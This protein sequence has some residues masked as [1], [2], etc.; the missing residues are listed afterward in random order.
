M[1]NGFDEAVDFVLRHEGGYSNN[2]KDPGGETNFGI[3][4]RAYPGLYLS[5]LTRDQAKEIYRRDFW[6]KLPAGLPDRL[7]AV[8]FDCAVNCG[9]SRA[10]RLLQKAMGVDADGIWGL[11]SQAAVARLGE[12]E[13]ISRFAT[14]RIL[15]Y[16]GLKEFPVFGKGWVKRVVEGVL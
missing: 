14:E 13:C 6:D 15:F 3:S 5:G 11:K 10:T 4:A 16:A 2:P 9:L 12:A 8:V 1:M 7:S